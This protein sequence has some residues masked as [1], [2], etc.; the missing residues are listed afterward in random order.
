MCSIRIQV[1]P[2][3]VVNSHILISLAVVVL[4]MKDELVRSTDSTILGMSVIF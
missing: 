2:Y 4:S 1:F 3:S